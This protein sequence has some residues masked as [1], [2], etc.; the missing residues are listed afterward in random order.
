[1][2][3][4]NKAQPTEMATEERN[5]IRVLIAED[6]RVV[7]EGLVALLALSP[8]FEVV[9]QACD[10]QEAVDLFR[11][12]RPDVTLM[13]LRMPRMDGLAAIQNILTDY[14]DARIIVLTTFAG[15]EENCLRA[16]AR[17]VALK[18]AP[19]DDLLSAIREVNGGT[20]TIVGVGELT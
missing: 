3:I 13:D 14:P 6:H 5:H 12:H 11:E 7:R 8:G 16:G 1:M 17:S 4:S 10:G 19:L 18:D 15:E 2:S 9:A 20:T